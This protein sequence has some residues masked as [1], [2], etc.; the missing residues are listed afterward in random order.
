MKKT[1]LWAVVGGLLCLV[2]ILVA[3]GTSPS[4]TPTAK[5]TTATTSASK[6]T[7]TATAKPTVAPT[8]APTTSAASKA[9]AAAV[10]FA[11]KTITIIVPTTP[12]GGT[13]IQ[14]RIFAR[15]L[16]QFLPGKPNIIVRN[17]PGGDATIGTNYFY[18]S[19]P[20]GLTLMVNNTT[21]LMS[22]VMGVSSAKFD[23]QK[24]DA[25]I[26]T[27]AGA[28]YYTRPKVLASPRIEDY[29]KMKG[30]IFGYTSGSA[31]GYI[32]VMWIRM[33][34]IVPEKIILAYPGSGDA[35]R[36]FETGET[37]AASQGNEAYTSV[38]EPYVKKGEIVVIFETGIADE[39]G[40]IVSDPGLAAPD[41]PTG[42]QAYEKAFG[43]PASGPDWEAYRALVAGTRTYGNNLLIPPGAS[44]E[45]LRAYFDAANQMAKDAGFHKE[46]DPLVGTKSPWIVGDVLTR[47]FRN[48]MKIDPKV[49]DYVEKTLGEYGVKIARG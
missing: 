10:N 9:P 14:S 27:A 17:M 18:Q 7:T 22:Y 37:N 12:G 35:R 28:Y 40:K 21:V 44:P 34:G 39:T 41:I 46:V 47:G 20:D 8:A 29:P 32:F 1:R 24:V 4:P 38:S 49:L 2:L 6:T 43:K 5:T 42:P 31:A 23:L 15:H 36:A 11:G 13:D 3:C 30:L 26:G 25:I 45:V 48:A 33:M 19:R 16:G